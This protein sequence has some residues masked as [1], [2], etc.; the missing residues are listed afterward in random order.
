VLNSTLSSDAA[1]GASTG[2]QENHKNALSPEKIPASFTADAIAAND[3]ADT[4]ETPDLCKA[5]LRYAK[6]GLPVFACLPGEGK[7]PLVK[8]GFHAATIDPEQ[9]RN[10]WTRWPNAL[11]G[12]P[13]GPR[14]GLFCVDLDRKTPQPGQAL[15]DGV[16]T[17]QSWLASP[18]RS[19]PWPSRRR[20]VASIYFS[21]VE[22]A[23]GTSASANL[24]PASRSRGKAAM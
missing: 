21:S 5:A 22:R 18:G 1:Q 19:P 11:I 17:W 9:I 2:P 13:M 7:R 10:W 24:V 8:T 23:S 20:A 14:S 3:A 15:E 4:D 12:V 16:A 6:Q